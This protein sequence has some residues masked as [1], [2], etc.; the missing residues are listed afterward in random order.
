[1][2][3]LLN[4]KERV[5]AA[6]SEREIA[7]AAER[8]RRLALEKSLTP[9]AI[10]DVFE[11]WAGVLD[12]G[13]V[14][15]I[16]GVTF[17]RL[18]L[19]RGTLEPI[20][21]RELG[22]E[23][24]HGG[25]REDGRV[26]FCSFPLGVVGHWPAGNIEVQP[27]L[28]LTCALLGGN[29]CIVR[30]PVGLAEPTR[31]IIDALAQADRDGIVMERIFLAHFD[32]ARIDLHEA[33]ARAVDGAM[34]WGGAESV[35]Q[36]RALSFPHWARV[37]AFGPRVSVA[38]M[39]AGTWGDKSDRL[40]W[41]RRMAR[42]VWQFDQQACSSPQTLFLEHNASCDPA[43]FVE[44]LKC[45][46]EE[47]NRAHPRAEIEP[48]L[49]SAI[50]RAR[51]S[52]LLDNTANR[53]LFPQSP[54]WTILQGTGAEIPEP[55]QGRT[56]TVLLADDLMDVVSRFDGTVQTLGLGMRD[57]NREQRLAEIAGRH[58]VD[59]IVRLGQ[60]HVF[61]S[62]WDGMDLVRPMMRLVR[63]APSQD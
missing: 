12:K 9:D 33:M 57:S 30:V 37:V 8:L 62:P 47:E 55:T 40:S 54:D 32:H 6:T 51:S 48:S 26:R 29:S 28:S 60:M 4:G 36:V 10:L 2:N 15:D 63:Y 27:I 41:C 50:C 38:A 1:M 53:G 56:L 44:D 45:A 16:P 14:R 58:G 35:T 25:W 5:Q 13:E 23:A 49:T 21:A 3:Q 31:L 22:P 59:R 46:F 39:D 18:W 43:E 17:L 7:Q 52:W 19:R 42:D 20:L 61:S 11:R 34:I 24:L